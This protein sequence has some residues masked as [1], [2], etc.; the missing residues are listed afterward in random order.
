VLMYQFRACRHL[1]ALQ[2]D[3]WTANIVEQTLK[4]LTGLGKPFKY[5]GES[6]E[7]CAACLVLSSARGCG[8]MSGQ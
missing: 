3:G 6:H 5:I 7:H 8:C 4:K 1:L 2:V